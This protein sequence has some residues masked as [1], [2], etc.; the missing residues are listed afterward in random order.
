MKGKDLGLGS[1]YSAVDLNSTSLLCGALTRWALP[2][3]IGFFFF[4]EVHL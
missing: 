2:T 3:V 4:L 1:C